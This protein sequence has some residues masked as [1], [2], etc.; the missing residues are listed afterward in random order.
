MAMSL[1]Q[2][3]KTGPGRLSA[4]KMLLYGGKI[5]KIGLV[6]PVII[7]LLAVIKK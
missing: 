5:V 7:G 2:L 4:L 6:V 3:K 1:E